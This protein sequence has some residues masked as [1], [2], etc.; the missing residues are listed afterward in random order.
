MRR[1]RCRSSRICSIPTSG[2]D[3][4][5]K[6]TLDQER[7]RTLFAERQQ[8]T[9]VP[10]ADALARRFATDWASVR[11]DEPAFLGLRFRDPQ[12]LEEL[13]PYIDWSP[14]FQ[15]WELR[16]KYPSIFDDPNCRG[17]SQAVVRRRAATADANRRRAAADGAGRVRLLAGQL[18]RRRHPGLRR[19]LAQQDRLP[20][21][22][23]C[24]SNGSAR[25]RPTSARWPITSP[26]WTADASITSA[27]SP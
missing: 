10:Y 4:I 21:S 23:C 24:G 9:L 3:F 13:V 25:G 16:G 5:K 14:F 7:D 17:R 27:P 22:P 8:K 15:T 20:A 19:S 11:I 2:T 6:N 18:R 26:R 1:S 12:P